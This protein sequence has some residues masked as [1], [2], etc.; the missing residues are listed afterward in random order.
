MLCQQSFSL[1]L[2]RHIP[3]LLKGRY[4][5]T[6]GKMKMLH[7]K[8]KF[9]PPSAGSAG[10]LTTAEVYD[11]AHLHLLGIERILHHIDPKLVS[12]TQCAQ[13]AGFLLKRETRMQAM[14][15]V[16]IPLN[17]ALQMLDGITLT[18]SMAPAGS[19]QSTP[20][21]IVHLHAHYDAQHSVYELQLV[22]E[23]M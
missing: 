12:A 11:D 21:R 17:P 18:D 19:G 8:S 20:G 16:T 6:G 9:T 23:G 22:L 3:L 13:K 14:Y 2:Y 7:C 1:T 10:A 5:L 15:M 4:D